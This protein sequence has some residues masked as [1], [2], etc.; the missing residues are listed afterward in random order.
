[1]GLKIGIVGLPNVGKSTLFNA[2]IRSA[3][4]QAANYPFCTIEP[5]IGAVEVPDDRLTHIARLEGSAKVTPTFIEFVDIAGLV[6][7]ASKG[8]GLGNQFLAHIREVD[9]IAMVLRCFERE[10]IAH[11]E[12]SVNPIRDA[13][14]VDIELIAKDLE[15]VSRRLERVEKTARGGDVNAKEELEHLQRIRE[16]L[17]ELEPLRKYRDS[18]P[19]ETLR[20][21][22]RT[23]FLLTLKPVMFVANIGEEDLPEGEANPHFQKLRAKA[24]EEG[25][26]VIAICAEIESQMIDLSDEERRELLEA[27]GLREPGLHRVIR[28]GYRLL[29][30]VT[31]FTTGE[32]ETRAWTVVRGTKAPEAA[33]KIHTDMEKGFIRAEVT[34]YEDYIRSGGWSR[35]KEKGLVRLEGRDYEVQDG[36]IIYFRFNV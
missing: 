14:V 31:F 15:T 9:A 20:Y 36:D 10:G 32:K 2:L 13:E 33:G 27:Y 18:L 35:A 5:N 26:P 23:L 3:K 24:G 29:N 22:E 8:E 7:G 19:E 11:V 16:I 21:A 4:A 25:I 34:S 17:D 28:E 1:M 6:K 30:L 12:G